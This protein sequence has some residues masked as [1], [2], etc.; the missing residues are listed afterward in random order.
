MQKKKKNIVKKSSFFFL[1]GKGLQSEGNSS[2]RMPY[3]KIKR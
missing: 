1:K 2:K 3:D